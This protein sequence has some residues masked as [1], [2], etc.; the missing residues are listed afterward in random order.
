MERALTRHIKDNLALYLA[1]FIFFLGGITAGTVT[2]YYL[3]QQQVIQLASYLDNLLQQFNTTPQMASCYSILYQTFINA[4]KEIG[5]VWFLGLT[6]IGLPLIVAIIFFKGFILGF[7]VG[8]LVQQKASQGIAFSLL[9]ILPPNLLEIPALFVAA[10]LGI[11]F[12]I[13]LLRG[14]NIREAGFLPR[15]LAYTLL[16]FLVMVLVAGG[17]LVEA[18]LS[19]LFARIV[20]NYF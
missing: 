1:V 13:S 19:P 15:F 9:A 16:M 2:L 17:G 5:M 14:R 6:V 20:L 7:T 18:Y 12:S 3:G 11:S 10:I 8:F 4:L